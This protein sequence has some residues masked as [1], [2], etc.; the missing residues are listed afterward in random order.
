[1]R[2]EVGGRVMERAVG[3]V[4][5]EE[6]IDSLQKGLLDEGWV[7]SDLVLNGQELPHEEFE[8]RKR[9][10]LPNRHTSNCA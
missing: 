5:L 1:M 7:I 6:L 3:E 8:R 10:L 2:I 9:E 4:K